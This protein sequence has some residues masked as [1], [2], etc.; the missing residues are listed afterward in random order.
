MK[1]E[2]E[3]DLQ[4]VLNADARSGEEALEDEREP[5]ENHDVDIVSH[6]VQVTLPVATSSSNVCV[7]CGDQTNDQ[8]K[9]RDCGVPC[10]GFPPCCVME[11]NDEYE[12]DSVL[13]SLCSRKKEI[14]IHRQ[15]AKRKQIQQAERM[16]AC[17][18]KRFK[19]AKAGD[20]VMVPI[21]EV[22]RGRA[23]FRNLKAVVLSAEEN[24]L[25][26]IGTRHGTLHQLY[27]RN[28]FIPCV[29]SFM[30]LDEVVKDKEVS[31]RE[32]ARLDSIGTGQGFFKC[33]CSG[34]CKNG[35]CKCFKADVK[36]NSRCHGTNSKCKNK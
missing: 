30:G 13:C 31:L 26:R 27:S 25:Y 16:L 11:E 3:E 7:S 5:E 6:P 21:P 28:Q 36:C 24:G 23:E 1:L 35:R 10:H 9:C 22:D 12:E 19:P 32:A 18:A 20:T 29:E 33:N 4:R 2:T 34:S 17:S 14:V 8:C 15:G